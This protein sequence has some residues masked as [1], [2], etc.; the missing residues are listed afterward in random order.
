M[1]NP[2]AHLLSSDQTKRIDTE[3]VLFKADRLKIP[4]CHASPSG[5]FPEMFV[6]LPEPILYST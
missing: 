6:Q 3:S 4:S 5:K 2:V 1:A